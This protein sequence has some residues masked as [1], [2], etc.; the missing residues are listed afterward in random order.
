[1]SRHDRPKTAVFVGCGAAKQ[2]ATVPARE[3]YTSNYFGLKRE[4]AET[5]GD[6]W[7]ILSALHGVVEP[8]ESISPYNVTI[9]DYP[10]DGDERS[11]VEHTTVDE[12]AAAVLG[13]VERRIRKPG[14]DGRQPD[15]LVILAGRKYVEPLRDGFGSL[16]VEHGFETVYPFDHTSG[17]GEQMGWL[18]EQIEAVESACTAP[19]DTTEKGGE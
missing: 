18:S 1:M 14:Q 19:A 17:I 6:S 11:Q 8:N 7:A 12:W 4:Y 3:L 15:R 10:I 2:D 16:A 9:D 5:V 13:D